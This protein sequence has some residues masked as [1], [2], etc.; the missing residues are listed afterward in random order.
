[1]ESEIFH[2]YFNIITKRTQGTLFAKNYNA[3]CYMV[4]I[5]ITRLVHA[6]RQRS[7]EHINEESCLHY[8][9]PM[10]YTLILNEILDS[11]FLTIVRTCL[12]IV[13]IYE[14][15]YAY[16]RHQY[17]SFPQALK[18]CQMVPWFPSYPS[19]SRTEIEEVAC[20]LCPWQ[21]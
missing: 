7:G 11:R 19:F 6:M 16:I 20:L 15:S 8:Y 21:Q 13:K 4:F 2:F 1:M 3:L 5:Q 14:P 17:C 10:C 9:P 18:G 12:A